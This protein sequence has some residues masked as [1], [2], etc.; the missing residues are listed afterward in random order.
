MCSSHSASFMPYTHLRG[1]AAAASLQM[2]KLGVQTAGVGSGAQAPVGED[3]V[4]S[5]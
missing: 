1:R 3:S 4:L 5:A 2:R